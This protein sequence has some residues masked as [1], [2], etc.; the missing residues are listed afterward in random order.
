MTP[1]ISVRCSDWLN[2]PSCGGHRDKTTSSALS[3]ICYALAKAFSPPRRWGRRRHATPRSFRERTKCSGSPDP[4]SCAREVSD[5]QLGFG[6]RLTGANEGG[7]RGRNMPSCTRGNSQRPRR[8]SEDRLEIYATGRASSTTPAARC[9]CAVHL[10][11]DQM[12]LRRLR[13]HHCRSR[14]CAI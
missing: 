12:W 14:A 8:R 4:R 9:R 13:R 5:D 2:W 10:A 7:R 11:R 1:R 6:V 3:T